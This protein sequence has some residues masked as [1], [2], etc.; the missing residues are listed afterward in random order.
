MQYNKYDIVLF[1]LLG[2]KARIFLIMKYFC[3]WR[4]VLITIC[5]STLLE[6]SSKQ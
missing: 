3:L 5:H 2:V 1:A 6:V 4:F